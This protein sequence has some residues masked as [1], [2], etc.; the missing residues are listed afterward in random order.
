MTGQPVPDGGAVGAI[1]VK[2]AC[3]ILYDGLP[4]LDSAG[5]QEGLRLVAEDAVAEWAAPS[6][7]GLPLTAGQ[8]RFGAHRI[9]MIALDAPVKEEVLARTV[10]VSPMPEELREEMLG[11]RAAIR[12]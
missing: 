2:Q 9:A 3:T 5:L 6:R 1:E 11:H 12:L 7:S 10:R 4:V 8:A